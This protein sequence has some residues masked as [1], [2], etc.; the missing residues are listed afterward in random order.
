MK[1]AVVTNKS[2]K[3]ELT[4]QGLQEGGEPEWLET[5]RVVSRAVAYIDLLFTP[6]PDRIKTLNELQP[7]LI[8]VNELNCTTK[9]LAE[10]FIRFNGWNS[11]LKRPLIEAAGGNSTTRIFAEKIFSCFGK[12]TE[13]VPDIPGFIS[14]R[15]VSMIINEAY[16]TLEEKVSSKEE[17]DIA[18]KLGTNYPYGPFEWSGLIGLQN[19]YA[20]LKKLAAGNARYT[21]ADL[22]MKEATKQ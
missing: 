13:W 10:G 9:E 14:A 4:A 16:F 18:M 11:F 5:P 15:V 8:L 20:L 2:L 1:I 12:K 22:L 7:A 3:E 6:E 19:I 17:I 21:A